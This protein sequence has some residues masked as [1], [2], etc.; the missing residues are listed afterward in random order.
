MAYEAGLR[1]IILF[2]Y[3]L[4]FA[5]NVLCAVLLVPDQSHNLVW[6]ILVTISGLHLVSLSVGA[7]LGKFGPLQGH[8]V[9]P[10][11]SSTTVAIYL[12]FDITLFVVLGL[13]VLR[14]ARG[15]D[16]CKAELV[17]LLCVS[18]VT[19]VLCFYKFHYLQNKFHQDTSTYAPVE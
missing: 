4:Y 16:D 10:F 7:C 15:D 12:L 8:R 5:L 13:N 14:M 2:V 17:A 19:N 6:V 18:T 9:Y 1:R 11:L 3:I